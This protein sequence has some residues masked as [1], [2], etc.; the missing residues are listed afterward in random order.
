MEMIGRGRGGG[1]GGGGGGEEASS[2]PPKSTNGFLG[3]SLVWL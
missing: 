3:T 2:A 1:G